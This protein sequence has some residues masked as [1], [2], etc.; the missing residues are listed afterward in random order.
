MSYSPEILLS[1][2]EAA[3]VLSISARTLQ[4]WRGR[5]MGPAFVRA[6][7]AIRYRGSDIADWISSNTTEFAA[8][9]SQR[10]DTR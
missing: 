3:R 6:G 1:E 7:R 5:K 2:K 9:A 10:A 8:S 4:G